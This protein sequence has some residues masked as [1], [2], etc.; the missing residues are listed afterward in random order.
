[1]LLLTQLK[2]EV[3]V[4]HRHQNISYTGEAGLAKVTWESADVASTRVRLG[5]PT[6]V[7]CVAG[8]LS[9]HRLGRAEAA[10]ETDQR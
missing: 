3:Y 7:M 1:M 8:A 5:L 4:L 2:N 6:W 9:P 10:Q